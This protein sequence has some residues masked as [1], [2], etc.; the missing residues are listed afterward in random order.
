MTIMK[1]LCADAIASDLFEP[2]RDQGHDVVIEPDLA[3]DT[4]PSRLTEL[5]A[6]VLVVRSTKVTDA[7]ITATPQ[8]G[9]VVRAGA[10]T[11]NVDKVAASAAG[12]YVCNVPG[13][14]A[15][16]VAELAMGLLLAID[17]HIAAGMADFASGQW[18]KGLYSSA[19]GIYGKRLA[20][21]GL[22]EIGFALAERA[23]AFGMVVTALRKPGRSQRSLSRI[24]SAGITLVDDLD[25]LLG[26]ADVVSIHVPKSPDTVGM[27]DD[28]FLSKM[29]EGAILL[30]TSRGEVVEEAALI[31]AMDNRGIR[32]GLDVWPNEP[33]FKAGEWS[34]PLSTHPNVVGTHH[35][36]AS[37]TQAQ[38]AVAAG[39]VD[40]ITAYTAGRITNCVNIDSES[41]GRAI[42]T[43]RHLDKVG[44][45]AKIFDSLRSAGLN[46]SQMD[47]EVFS[48]AIA[49]VASINIDAEPNGELLDA[50]RTDADILDVSV[51]E[52][53]GKS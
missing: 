41:S 45:L 3:A 31:S 26:D 42:L 20:I 53:G 1:I 10:G 5:G 13:Q 52:L 4:I 9:L 34:S 37:T 32:A 44:V 8:L 7:A 29:P 39:T 18:N 19:D 47:N 50:L 33:S 22:G 2:L 23:N 36:G 27:V 35:I 49:A 38:D 21:L 24:R 51:A 14:N 25:T 43:V 30:N 46:V 11:D 15:I 16:A 28:D 12:V 17:R 40:V 48:G 6:N